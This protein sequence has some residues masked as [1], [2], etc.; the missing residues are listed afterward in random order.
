MEAAAC[1]ICASRAT[2][3][4]GSDHAVQ[5]EGICGW[6]LI[7]RQ[8]RRELGLLPDT[9]KGFIQGRREILL[10]RI[11]KLRGDD[12]TRQIRIARDLSVHFE[13]KVRAGAQS[14][15][16]PDENRFRAMLALF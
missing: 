13:G 14:G 16:L 2:I 1:Y 15:T 9:R 3:E 4:A 12:A 11:R 5:C 7:T 10:E 6:Y 8:A